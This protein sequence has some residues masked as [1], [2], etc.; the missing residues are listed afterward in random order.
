MFNRKMICIAVAAAC[1]APPV[2]AESAAEKI[3]H[4]N[5]SIAVLSAEKAE[6]ELKSQ[7]EAK[8]AEINKLSGGAGV[9]S[10]AS[11]VDQVMPVVRGI[12]GI[13]GKLSATLAFGGGVQQTVKTG[14]KTRGGWT[15]TQIDV[16][17]VTLVRGSEKTRLGFGTE[18]QTLSPGTASQ[19]IPFGR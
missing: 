1:L 15:V 19:G 14:E 8:R 5:E 13:D 12:E 10:S 6:L 3:A 9:S 11:S 7:I 16:N 4:I 17:S 18:P 2:F